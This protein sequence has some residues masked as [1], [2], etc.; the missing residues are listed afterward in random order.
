M[1]RVLLV[2]AVL[3]AG[4]GAG[5]GVTPAAQAAGGTVVLKFYDTAGNGTE[6]SA[7]QVK[8]VM[9]GSG[10]SDSDALVDPVTL[11]DVKG[12]PLY[13]SG[14]PARWRFD[15]PRQAVAF[16][17]NWPTSRGFSTVVVDNGGAGFTAGRTLVFNQQAAEDAKRRLDA[18]LAARPDY[19]RSAAFTAALADAV[20]NLNAADAATTDADRGKYGQ[21]ALSAVNTAND[22]LLSE[23]GPAYARAH[24]TQP[25]IG[26]TVDDIASHPNWAALARTHTQP[27]GWVRI[28]FDPIADHGNVEHYRGAVQAARAAGLHVIGQPIDSTFANRYT[29]AEYLA[30]VKAYVDAY[31]GIEAWEVANEVNGCW[32]DSR[33]DAKGDCVDEL[34][35]PDDRIR[36]KIADAAA[37]VRSKGAKVVVTLYWQ[38]GTDEARW[39]TFTWARAN[40]PAST[41][42]DID[43]VTLST[44]VEDAPMGLAFDQVMRALQAEFP[45][46]KVAVGELD[47]WSDDTTKAFWA[48]DESDPLA[49]R[50]AVAA[51]YY[52]ASLGYPRSVGG[53]FWWYFIQE[54]PGDAGLQKA[55][56]SV[57]DRL[58]LT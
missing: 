8:T 34:V 5:L 19:V 55:I 36:N 15:I 3:A 4:L 51:H 22:L 25:W 49:G 32:V 1:K 17:V 38:L 53:A 30:R 2:L 37:Y 11:E 18:A 6:L 26:L 52:A 20:T 43:V 40:L 13:K 16:A 48:F 31:P 24:D 41:R 45:D 54:L 42:R 10:G 58:T 35:D 47:Y 29:R 39:S 28:V 14:S 9:H 21:R 33:T 46:Q 23:Y 44:Y 27:Y 50:R 7:T 57:V 12:Y 56:R